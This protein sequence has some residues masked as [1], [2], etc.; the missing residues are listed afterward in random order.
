VKVFD[1]GVAQTAAR[2]ETDAGVVR[3]TY[4]YMAP[5]QIRGKPLDKRADVF[6]V[7]VVLYE[8]LTG[9]RLYQGNDV[10]IMTEVVEKDAP[11]P[12]TVI[13]DFPKELEQI[14]LKALTRDRAQ[15]SP[16]AAHLLMSL[17]Q[18]CIRNKL[19]TAPLVVS[20]FVRALFP[21]ERA[22][23]AGM[24]L[25]PHFSADSER[26]VGPESEQFEENLLVEELRRLS[27]VPPADDAYQEESVEPI[28]LPTTAVRTDEDIVELDA[29]E[30]HLHED[31]DFEY[32][33][34][35]ETGEAGALRDDFGLDEYADDIAV[36]PVVVLSP[37]PKVP[38][39]GKSE[40]DFVSELGRR[41][42]EDSE[43]SPKK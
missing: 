43:P 19:I 6:A 8:L 23:E 10:Q 20:K 25:V 2:A 17:E 15:R 18:F 37:K 36:K 16:S 41:L 32:E 12:S 22:Q 7:G 24:G 27:Q 26:E 28:E 1:F 11:P 9:R 30:L 38:D 42:R 34:E 29:S 21:Y 13:A 4:A 5:E 14:V 33:R 31:E 3:G 40:G 39:V 35:P